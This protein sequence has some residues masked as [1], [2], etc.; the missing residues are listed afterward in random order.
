MT[1][2][3][4][5]PNKKVT[6]VFNQDEWDVV[7]WARQKFGV[8]MLKEKLVDWLK[9]LWNQKEDERLLSSRLVMP[10]TIGE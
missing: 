9:A 4:D 5:G 8:N 6:I 7:I 2:T 1:I 10:S 3:T